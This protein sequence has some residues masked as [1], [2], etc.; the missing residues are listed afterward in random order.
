[1]LREGDFKEIQNIKLKDSLMPLNRKFSG[2]EGKKALEGYD[3]VRTKGKNTNLLRYNTFKERFFDNDERLMI[4][5]IKN[6]NHK[7]KRIIKL[8]EKIDVYD[9]EVPNTHNFAL[10]SGVFVHNSSIGGRDRK[11]QAI[12]PLRGKVL[13]V[14][15]ARLDKVFKNNEIV[16]LIT[17]LGCGVG[18]E[19]NIGKL[20]YHKII[21]LS[22]ADVDGQHIACLLLTFFYRYMK[23]LIEKGYV[24]VA[25]PPLYNIKKGGKTIYLK[26]DAELEKYGKDKESLKVQR[27]KGLGEMNPEQ[28][29]ETSLDPEK[30]ILKRVSVEDA[31]IADQ[32]FATLMGDEVEPRREFIVEYAKEAKNID[33]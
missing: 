24:Y 2:K 21:I 9:I 27:F 12:L 3:K 20:R 5:A 11:F 16:N 10:A 7:I 4:D 15:K 30:R 19:F 25:Q 28:L 1:M 29:W 18:E 26:D 23:S 17:A 14:E 31:I 32:I 22:D 8:K 13:N 6:Y 33:I